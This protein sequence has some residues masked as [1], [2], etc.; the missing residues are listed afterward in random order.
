MTS[1]GC[2]R[3]HLPVERLEDPVKPVGHAQFDELG[4]LHIVRYA[5]RNLEL[6]DQEGHTA[7]VERITT[8]TSTDELVDGFAAF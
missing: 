8:F 4:E 5:A 1:S 7:A 2:A 3:Q 6:G